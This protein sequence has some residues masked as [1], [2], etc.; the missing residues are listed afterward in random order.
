M[1]SHNYYIF[2]EG[3]IVGPYPSEQILQWNLA[4]DTQVCI[5][6][7]EE[8]LLLSQAPELLAQPDSGSSLP[9][10]Y[11]K[12]DSTSNRKS[13]FIIHGRGNTLDNAFRLLIQLVRTKI[14]FYQ[15]C[16]FA[17][18]ENSN[19][20]RFLLYDTHS[21]PYTLLFDRIIVGKIALC[22]FYPPPE[23]WIPDSTWTKLS[24]FK[25]T[26]KLE[27]YA[28][29]QG[30]AGEGKRKWCDEFFQAIWQDASKMLG[31]VITSQP[32]LSETLEGIRSRLMPPDGG[33]YLEKE[34][35]IAI[36][37]Y[38]SERGLNPEP[39]QE[40]LLEFQRLNDAGGD[41]DTIASNALYGAWFMQWFEKQNV[42][43]PRYGKDFEFDFVNYHQSFLHLARHKNAD[44][45]L[46]DFPMEAIP[47]LED[48]SRAL[49]EVGS[50]FVRIDDHHPLDSK[51]I[52]LLERLKSE[53]LAGEYMMSGPIK[54]EGEQAEEER[55]CGS[56]LVHRAMLE[57][58][59]F[60]APGLD[61]LRR[62]AHQQD[63]HLIKDPDDREHPDYLAVDLSKLIG[64]KYSRI[65]MTQQLMFVR[66]YVSIREIMNTTGWR[67]IVDEYEVELERTC[68]KL[69][70]NLALI[71]YL[72]PEDIEEYRGSMGA[73]SMLGSIVKKITF[74]KV[75]LELKAIQ[76]KLPSRT[77]KILITL[78]PFQSRKEHR[79]NVASA[80]NY[81]KRYYSFDY[82]FFAWGSSLLTT[83]RFKDEDTTINLSE[84]MPIMGGPGD[85]GH[86]SAATCKP[87]S[88]AAWPAHRFSK[89][90]RH[91]FLDY[92]NYIAG[93]IKEGLKHEI[94]SVRSITIKD[95]DI[96]GYSSNKRR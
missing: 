64:S 70:E 29:P 71:E 92:A 38:F 79:I 58:T 81:L 66:S 83:R 45:Y 49:R 69:E 87:P 62:L 89:L 35:K 68:P 1:S 20:V 63:L 50:R 61:E 57:G 77:H 46:P 25:V 47:D 51:Q 42:V 55:T 41:L 15:G 10:P 80:I 56:D 17:D 11:V 16:I 59:E 78:A 53:G 54:G 60:D 36:Q 26:D 76:S 94:V 90:N 8:W 31:Q 88:N 74:G 14:R 52:E 22:P 95:R 39:F 30:I 9:S 2:Y 18:S 85:G 91:N 48:A 43:P 27:T 12:Q 75:D 19:F 72:V 3:K 21:N 84:F 44:I 40:L 5:E 73:A 32:A 28:V 37:N 6:G 65:D 96:I 13:I 7:T 93:R 4:A 82:F 23:N 24:E 67:Q 34:Y 86:A 33:M